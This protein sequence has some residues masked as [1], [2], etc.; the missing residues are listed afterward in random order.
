[1]LVKKLDPSYTASGN[2]HGAAALESS[3]AAAQKVKYR[4]N[5]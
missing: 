2:V 1:M 5:I 4:V 3:L